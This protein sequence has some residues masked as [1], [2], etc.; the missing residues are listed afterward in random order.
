[1]KSNPKICV[2]PRLSGVG[3]MVSF[4]FKLIEGLNA[5]GVEVTQDLSD[6][7]YRSVL[8]I[9]GTR[10]LA[11]LWL[12]RRRGIPVI[13]RLNGM[14]WLHRLRSPEGE[15]R[16][17]WRH[18]LR[19]EYGNWILSTIRNRLASK[20]VYQSEFTVGWWER[21]H[22]P[23]PVP[24]RVIYNGVDLKSY[25]PEGRNELPSDFYRILMVEGS[26]MGGYEQGLQAAVYLAQRLSDFFRQSNGKLVEL[27]VV[28]KVPQA[29]QA[30]W[31]QLLIDQGSNVRLKVG[32]TGWA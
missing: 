22:G 8:V 25:S 31:E 5:R 10:Q 11:G 29:T 2:V 23:T 21:V 24:H 17:G 19:A 13:Q 26:L 3:G 7:D 28:G 1:L 20:I 4:Q 15:L 32:R 9:G 14:N 12:A 16:T 27:M 30:V 18:Y 6:Q